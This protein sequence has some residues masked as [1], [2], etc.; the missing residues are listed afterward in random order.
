MQKPWGGILHTS[1]HPESVDLFPLPDPDS[2]DLTYY[3]HARVWRLGSPETV[4]GVLCDRIVG[5]AANAQ[6]S[7]YVDRTNHFPHRIEI[8]RDTT[9]FVQHLLVDVQVIESQASAPPGL[10]E[11]P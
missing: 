3:R 10:F 9:R 1:P 6:F 11:K 2:D 7:F 5:E 8:R 4:H